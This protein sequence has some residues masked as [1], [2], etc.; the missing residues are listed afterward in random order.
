MKYIYR[1]PPKKVAVKTTALLGSIILSVTLS[2][3]AGGAMSGG[4]DV[5]KRLNDLA[6]HNQDLE[7]RVSELER[8]F[9][10]LQNAMNSGRPSP[11][12]GNTPSQNL[13]TQPGAPVPLIPPAQS[14]IVPPPPRLTVVKIRPPSTSGVN[15]PAA[16]SPS[17]N[18]DQPPPLFGDEPGFD[19]PTSAPSAPPDEPDQPSD[20]NPGPSAAPP[21]S[22][23]GVTVE[24]ATLYESAVGQFHKG[25][26]ELA[27]EAFQLYTSKYPGTIYEPSALFYLGECKFKLG[28]YSG[29]IEQFR[30][31][32]MKF[33][34]GNEAP[35]ALLRMGMSYSRME[36][37]ES[38]RRAFK[39]VIERFP[40]SPAATAARQELENIP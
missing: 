29:A 40:D 21:G 38:A 18:Q 2:A 9:A 6:M 23:A 32:M 35:M 20:Q 7:R 27:V 1:D 39:Q 22:G 31:Y 13:P 26:Y 37:R 11:G 16:E 19:E 12:S 36:D 5:T 24:A 17:G 10:L 28:Q 15:Q 34:A 30:R 4:G 25:E 3:C 14:K 33:P 8:K